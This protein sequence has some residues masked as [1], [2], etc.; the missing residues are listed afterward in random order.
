IWVLL[1]APA[2]MG[3]DPQWRDLPD[4]DEDK[5]WVEEQVAFP[6]APR[7]ENLIPL[8]LSATARNRFLVD[9][10]SVTLGGDSVLRYTMMVLTEGGARNVT[11]EGMRCETKEIR[12]YGFGRTD[13]TWS[14]ARHSEWLPLREDSRNPYQEVLYRDFLCP[15]RLAAASAEH[16][17]ARLRRCVNATV[18]DRECYRAYRD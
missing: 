18:V 13:G 3:A 8:K 5:P 10:L 2:L 6:V 1:L 9:A 15:N 17:V 16:V 11:Y 4:A 12:L 7:E 14:K